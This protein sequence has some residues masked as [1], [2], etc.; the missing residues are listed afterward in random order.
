MPNA[1]A[2][3]VAGTGT[4][5]CATLARVHHVRVHGAG[6]VTSKWQRCFQNMFL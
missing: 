5:A 6:A 1:L 4:Q 3:S 2:W